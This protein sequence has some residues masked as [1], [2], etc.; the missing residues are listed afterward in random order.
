MNNLLENVTAESFEGAEAFGSGFVDMHPLRNIYL[1]C[2]VLGDFNTIN[3]SGD[4]SIITRIPVNAGFGD[5]IYYESAADLDYLDCSRQT[6]SHI[7]LQ[8]KDTHGNTIN[9]NGAHNLF[10]IVSSR[11][12]SGS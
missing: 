10:S 8:L 6:L 1:T 12:Q 2:S 11:F 4:Q 7:S 3:V 9:M 5:V